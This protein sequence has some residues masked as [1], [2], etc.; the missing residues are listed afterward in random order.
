MCRE[1]SDLEK[2]IGQAKLDRRET[3]G[4]WVTVL[5]VKSSCSNRT[6]LSMWCYGREMS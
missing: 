6:W 3:R 4:N 5:P 1:N 2:R